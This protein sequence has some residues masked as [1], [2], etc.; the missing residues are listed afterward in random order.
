MQLKLQEDTVRILYALDD[1][2]PNGFDSLMKHQT[3]NRGINFR[4]NSD[5]AIL[6]SQAP[7]PP[8]RRE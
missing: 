5:L 6:R 8:W 1:N 4:T 3:L 2:V 7:G